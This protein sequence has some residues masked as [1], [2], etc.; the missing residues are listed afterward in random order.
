MLPTA[1]CL[2]ALAPL[3]EASC[4]VREGSLLSAPKGVLW[5]RLP[6]PWLPT[7]FCPSPSAPCTV[8][9]AVLAGL[10]SWLSLPLCRP[11][12]Q[13]ECEVSPQYPEP[14]LKPVDSDQVPGLHTCPHAHLRLAHRGLPARRHCH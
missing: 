7:A 8:R 10:G 14:V 2:A 11:R 9:V 5:L 6:P 3:P 4:V 12:V 13:E 1:P